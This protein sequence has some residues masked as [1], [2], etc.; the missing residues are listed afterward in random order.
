MHGVRRCETGASPDAA[1]NA[2]G[3]PAVWCRVLFVRCLNTCSMLLAAGNDLSAALSQ[4]RSA[5]VAKRIWDGTFH[6]AT[7]VLTPS[8][9]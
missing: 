8:A 7:L 2:V 6:A 9:C 1:P 4:D 5:S 3:M